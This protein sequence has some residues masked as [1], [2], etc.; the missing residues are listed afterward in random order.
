MWSSVYGSRRGGKREG[1]MPRLKSLTCGTHVCVE[2]GGIHL[3]DAVVIVGSRTSTN[4]RELLRAEKYLR[5]E[6][7]VPVVAW[8]NMYRSCR[9]PLGTPG[10][11]GAGAARGRVAGLVSRALVHVRLVEGA[12]GSAVVRG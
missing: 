10:A 11:V 4:A 3:E 9:G 2:L 1:E 5:C 8:K 12:V 7:P 6:E